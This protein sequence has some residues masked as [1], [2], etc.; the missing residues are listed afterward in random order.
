MR[1]NVL[2]TA[3]ALILLVGAGAYFFGSDGTALRQPVST[4]AMQS[5]PIEAP[6]SAINQASPLKPTAQGEPNSDSDPAMENLST[7]PAEAAVNPEPT[8]DNPYVDREVKARLAQVADDYAAQ[9]QYPSF[10]L[11]IPNR[12]ALQKYLPNRGFEAARPLDNEDEMSPR[13][14]VRTDKQ[15]YFSG[16]VIVVTA[17]LSGLTGVHRISVQARLI[18]GGRTLATAD[19]VGQ[20]AAIYQMR[21]V[22]PETVPDGGIGE[23][24]VV[25]GIDIDG[26]TY[27]IGTPVTYAASVSEVTHVGMAQV[28]GEYL[29]I[30]VYVTTT[31]PGYHELAANLYGGE[32]GEPLVHLSVQAEL[33]STNALMQLKAHVASLKVGGDPGPYVLRDIVFTRMPSAPEFITEYGNASQQAYEVNGYAFD[34][35]DDAPYVNEE[36]GKRLEFLRQ[37]G[38]M[39]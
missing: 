1:A 20:Q 33:Q 5:S 27:E 24:R 4:S 31:K 10:S 17:S 39:K 7:G 13:I 12:E 19:A 14:H 25:A 9:I 26:K 15:L 16:D 22:A 30:P 11:P 37:I 6:Q 8:R 2:I 36:A 18:G 34:E 35:Y 38:S 21:L 28:S 32:S 23:Y 3:S 29:N